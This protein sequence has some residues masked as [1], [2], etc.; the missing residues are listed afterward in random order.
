MLSAG[1]GKKLVDIA[2]A[3][4]GHYLEKGEIP[5]VKEKVAGNYGVF[6]TL[7]S[8]PEHELRGCIGFPRAVKSLAQAT[9]DAAVSAAVGDPRF[10]SVKK[11]E[12]GK[13]VVEVSALTPP[14][15]LKGRP[16]ERERQ[17]A[18]GKDGVIVEWGPC[19][20]LLLPQVATEQGWGAQELL[21]QC[22]WKAGLSPD[23]WLDEKSKVFKFQTQ[24]FTEARPGGPASEK[25]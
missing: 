21:C 19:S 25:K 11:G 14:Q 10:P 23:M 12:L 16:T 1:E 9:A 15:E 18:V 17:I 2:R 5:Q 6:V 4:I 8:H 13:I 24:I 22:C 3:A 7:Y 20:G